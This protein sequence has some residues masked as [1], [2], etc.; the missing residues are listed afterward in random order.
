[1]QASLLDKIVVTD[2]I[3]IPDAKQFDKL[4]VLTVA[5]LFAAAIRC[6]HD[7]RSVSALFETR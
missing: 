3:P 2:T 4:S 6:I 5:P 7:G 1:M